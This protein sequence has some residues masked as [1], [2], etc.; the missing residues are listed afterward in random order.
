MFIEANR[1]GSWGKSAS[2]NSRQVWSNIKTGN[3]DAFTQLYTLYY[4]Q[5]YN[6]GYKIAP[7]EELIKDCI[8][9]LFLAMWNQ[10]ETENEIHSMRSYLITAMRR[11]ILRQIKKQKNCHERNRQYI[12]DFFDG[13]HDAEDPDE[14]YEVTFNQQKLSKAINSLSTRQKEAVYLKYYD[15]LSNSEISYVM[16]INLQ[17]VYNHISG[18]VRQLQK[19]IQK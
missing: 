7:N 2:A 5:L 3:K 6:Y 18:A 8:Q 11:I 15:G 13:I 17:S 9:E 4:R 10:R 16:E 19:L 12:D 14:R 1:S